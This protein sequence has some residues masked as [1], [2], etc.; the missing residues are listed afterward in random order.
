MT[1]VSNLVLLYQATIVSSKPLSLALGQSGVV[2][3]AMAV[4][5]GFSAPRRQLSQFDVFFVFLQFYIQN[6]DF[7]D[8]NDTAHLKLKPIQSTRRLYIH[9]DSDSLLLRK[10]KNKHVENVTYSTCRLKLC[11]GKRQYKI[12][13]SKFVIGL[14]RFYEKIQPPLKQFHR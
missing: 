5:R 12:K 8:S 11:I 7:N 9:H 4:K 3:S 1:H 14:F 13:L 10:H 2:T 6:C